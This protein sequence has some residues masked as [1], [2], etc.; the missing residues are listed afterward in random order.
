MSALEDYYQTSGVDSFYGSVNA[1]GVGGTG[2]Q[3][4]HERLDSPSNSFAFDFGTDDDATVTANGTAADGYGYSYAFG[5][6]GAAGVGVGTDG[7]FSLI[8]MVQAPTFTGS[9]VFLNPGGVL[10]AANYA[11]ITASVAPG[12]LLTLFGS[13]LASATLSTQGGQ[14]FPT[15]LGGV[16]VMMNGLAA[17]IYYVSP[18]Q[19]SA[20]IPYELDPTAATNPISVAQIQVVNNGS[21]SNSFTWFLSDNIPGFFTLGQNGTGVVAAV[22]YDSSGNASVVGANNP[23]KQGD[24]L[25]LFLTGLGDVS[26]TIKDGAIGPTSTLSQATAFTNNYLAVYFDDFNSG[27]SAQA[28]HNLCRTGS[29]TCGLVPDECAGAD[30]GWPRQRLYR[31]RDGF[32]GQRSGVHSGGL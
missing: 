18:T 30:Y 16:Q 29:W 17:P 31:N 13:G 24:T 1:N 4:M 26:P 32:S 12:E 7:P 21:K 15:M 8:A 14:P 19:I 25:S 9:G 6:N 28:N 2:S 3:I 11:P 10:N 27:N 20:V 22:R 23:A 5:I